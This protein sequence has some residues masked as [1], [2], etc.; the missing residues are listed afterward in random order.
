MPQVAISDFC[1]SKSCP[2]IGVVILPY[3]VSSALNQ[4]LFYSLHAKRFVR[5]FGLNFSAGAL[6]ELE[7]IYSRASVKLRDNLTIPHLYHET[8]PIHFSREYLEGSKPLL[9]VFLQY[10][11]H[12]YTHWVDFCSGQTLDVPLLHEGVATFIES[13]FAGTVSKLK[14]PESCWSPQGVIYEGAAYLIAQFLENHALSAH[15]I[16]SPSVRKEIGD[17]SKE[18]ITREYL[19]KMHKKPQTLTGKISCLDEEAF[20]LRGL[21][22]FIKNGGFCKDALAQLY[23]YNGYSAVA[24]DIRAL[25]TSKLM[26]YYCSLGLDKQL[27]LVLGL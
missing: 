12:E 27:K 21:S 11:V 9:D 26:D 2:I 1:F 18:R 17:L 4:D 20:N 16:F 5:E 24:K 13:V 6:T 14:R 23:D 15:A 8:P 3:E 19:R 25:D 7:S 10:Y 22:F